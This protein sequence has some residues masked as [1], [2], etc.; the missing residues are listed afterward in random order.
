[1]NK[2][3]CTRS[4]MLFVVLGLFYHPCKYR[5]VNLCI[6]KFSLLQCT[7]PPLYYQPVL[8][9]KNTSINNTGTAPEEINVIDT[10]KQAIPD[11]IPRMYLV[12]FCI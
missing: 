3:N 1:M 10:F 6:N 12:I 7:K 2:L 9:S 5:L 8:A 11:E 4:S